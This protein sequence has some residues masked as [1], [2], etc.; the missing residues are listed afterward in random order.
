MTGSDDIPRPD[1]ERRPGLRAY[2]AGYPAV[3]LLGGLFFATSLMPS[4]IPRTPEIQGV[5][6]GLSAAVGF[7][8]TLAVAWTCRFL[9]IP[10]LQGG[11]RRTVRGARRRRGGGR[12]WALGA[13]GVAGGSPAP[14]R[15]R[16]ARQLL[17]ADRRRRGAP[18]RPR[19][20]RGRPRTPLARAGGRASAYRMVNVGSIKEWHVAERTKFHY[21]NFLAGSQR[22]VLQLLKAGLFALRPNPATSVGGRCRSGP[23]AGW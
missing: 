1:R 9:E 19:A 14:S 13:G 15:P 23:S 2:A 18:A 8:I 10:P 22:G 7:W 12:P 17:R 20:P 3:G 11:A 21:P 16:A 4:L 6:T 5:L